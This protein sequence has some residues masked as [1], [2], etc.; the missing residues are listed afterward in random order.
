MRKCT[1]L[2]RLLSA[3]LSAAILLGAP[4]TAMAVPLL[5]MN[6]GI[7]A[8]DVLPQGMSAGNFSWQQMSSDVLSSAAQSTSLYVVNGGAY[9]SAVTGSKVKVLMGNGSSWEQLLDQ[10][11][12]ASY[13]SL[14]IDKT[15]RPYV[16]YSDSAATGHTKVMKF[17]MSWTSLEAPV[18]AA[19]QAALRASYISLSADNSGTPYVAANQ[20][21]MSGR[22]SVSKYNGS[23]WEYVGSPSVSGD[24]AYSA[25]MDIYNGTPYVA[26]CVNDTYASGAYVT[27]KG[28]DGSQWYTLGGS[29]ISTKKSSDVTGA[30][31][32]M[33]ISSSGTPYVAYADPGTGNRL[34]VKKLSEGDWVTVGGGYLTAG[35]ASY[36]SLS[37]DGETPCVAYK[38][39][40]A[41]SN[42]GVT[43]KK[44]DAQSGSWATLGNTEISGS[45]NAKGI[46]LFVDSGIP[47]ISFS[48]NSVVKVMKFAEAPKQPVTISPGSASVTYAGAPIGLS[49][50]SGLFTLDSGAGARTYSLEAAP[51]EGSGEGQINGTSLSVTKA[52]V[53]KIGLETAESTTHLAGSKAIAT[54][55]VEKGM[56]NA[57]S[58][59]GAT[60]AS[61]SSAGDGKI[62]GLTSGIE[63]EYKLVDES[64]Y[65][66]ATA[67]TSGEIID[68]P[69]GAY[70][71]RH[72]DTPVYNASADSAPVTVGD[73]TS[74]TYSATMNPTSYTFAA[75]AANY[76]QPAEQQFTI[77]NTG[78]GTI[79]GVSASLNNADFTIT[80]MVIMSQIA[81]NGTATIGVQPKTGLAAGTHTGTLTVTGAEGISLT[82]A[83]SFKVNKIQTVNTLAAGSYDYYY[84]GAPALNMTPWFQYGPSNGK[85]VY[86]LE[87]GTTGS[88]SFNGH[89]LT[90]SSAG[91]FV[92]GLVTEETDI[93]EQTPKIFFIYNVFKGTIPAPDVGAVNATSGSS[94]GKIIWLRANKVCEYKIAGTS[95]YTSATTDEYGQI[96]GLPAGT[97]V[98]RYPDNDLHTASPDSEPVTIEENKLPYSA[99]V[100][101]ASHT[102]A[103]AE[104]NYTQPA[105][106]QFTITNNGT[107]T[108]T[109][110]SVSLNNADFTITNMVIVSQIAPNGTATIGVQPK[111]GLAAGTH[112]GT[113]TITGADGISLSVALSF[114][115]NKIQTSNSLK[116]EST[117]NNAY[118]GT[119]WELIHWINY[120][121]SNG[122]RVYT[123]EPGTTGQGFFNGSQLNFTD[124]GT[125]VVGLVTEETDIYAKTE[126]ILFTLNISKGTIYAPNI[127][128]VNTAA[129]S[130]NGKITGLMANKE[131]EYKLSGA[132][133]YTSATSNANGQITGLPAGTYVVRY[134]DN[135]LH[136]ASPDSNSVTIGEDPLPYSATVSESSHTFAAAVYG[137]NPQQPQEFTITNNGGST[138]TNLSASLTNGEG[139]TISTP[140]SGVQLA[141]N[142][143]ATVSVRPDTGLT[144]GTHNGTL[145]ITGDDGISLTVELTFVVNKAEQNRPEGYGAE[146][147]T[148]GNSDGKIINLIPGVRYEY[149]LMTASAYS[150]AAAD[151]NGKITGLPAG[152]YYIRFAETELYNASPDSNSIVIGEAEPQSSENFVISVTVP[153]GAVVNQ[154]EN[155]ITATADN[156]VTGL[157]VD[158]AVSTGASWKLYSDLGCTHEISRTM[159]L[160]LGL[161]TSY[162][163]VTAQNGNALI[164]TL[165]ITRQT[166]SGGSGSGDSGS[167]NSGSGGSGSA[168]A[169]DAASVIVNGESKSAGKAQT[170]TGSDGKTTK[171]VTVDS[172]RLES[173]LASEKSGATVVIPVTGNADKAAGVL[174]GQMVKIM[175]KQ[176]ATL[177]VR[178]DSATYTLP[179][180]EI[181]ITAVSQQLSANVELK[182]IT[183]AVS[184]SE[185]SSQMA[186]VV[187]NAAKD[188][189]F[190]LM[191]PPVDYTVTCSYG[192]RTVSVNN[193]NVYVERTVAI[194]DGVDPAKI[195]TGIVV[196]PD[197]TF[198]HVPTRVTIINGKYFAVI[199]SL[200]NSTYS[201][202]WNPV[203]FSDVN[204]HWAKASA[205]NMGSRMVVTG[206]GAGKYEPD[207]NMTR[208]EFATVIVKALGLKPGIGSSSFGD[209]D[210]SMWYSGYIKTAVAYGIIKGYNS[211]TFGPGDMITREQAFT[212]LANAMKTTGLNAALADSDIA[213]LLGTYEDGARVAKYAGS[214]TAACLKTGIVT[215]R[216]NNILAPKAYVTRAEVAVMVEKLLQKS[217]LI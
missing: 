177:E 23:A 75:A 207:R 161:N 166:G 200:T 90:V 182:D 60:N 141:P 76:T 3:V 169:S 146:N 167:G 25:S 98:V 106:Q 179:A 186:G 1:F 22:V 178:T 93:Y 32:S 13:T 35:E 194:P 86:T 121:P 12:T 73:A 57:P 81:P 116:Y 62:T 214:S 204:R 102:F 34:A 41:A 203:E 119:P 52:G 87:E 140:L 11:T 53:F 209:V 85:R 105:E 193:Y 131:C 21:N 159:S 168:G 162:I 24:Q 15:G 99:K 128:A 171:T 61:T 43:V 122:Q 125:F 173:I 197:G 123:L 44:L 18:P 170:T 142:A 217:K 80:N 117:Y 184:I 114:T 124:V 17:S 100:D 82:V 30:F 107:E 109:G 112:T 67:N 153:A 5:G 143:T 27:M 51:S 56:Q 210:S 39:G 152:E 132:S 138:I 31:V 8:Y 133:S 176:A 28:Y 94:D 195:T 70:V 205:N 10:S 29:Q 110:L 196:N 206:V 74:L 38:E 120:G 211:N 78:T 147:A 187:E 47:Y 190:S 65:L 111:T 101:P 148:V 97:Y 4:S 96:T 154:E 136:A 213:S 164:Y 64:S 71:V 208:A 103:A 91:T 215:G 50:I 63:Y 20:N 144:T 108:I 115:V 126:K 14:F 156:S 180:S 135:S 137:Y 42:A 127:G 89:L 139:F 79:T 54:L 113:L 174:T 69:V 45:G 2:R 129:G 198:Y 191:V 77:T 84:N 26:Y 181:D 16:A 68:L 202:V 83:L 6:G 188:G 40:G 104:V 172:G 212:M 48:T 92:V 37:L 59:L 165:K 160:N 66:K 149:R 19:N 95:T 192:G 145:S 58:G 158:V 216:K 199:N 157:T 118:N 130:S 72:P 150:E 9:V 163:K 46:S 185:P 55:T 201:V 183:V 36:I 49:S 33:K 155:T 151:A 7:V 189:G 88:G 175:E 134:P